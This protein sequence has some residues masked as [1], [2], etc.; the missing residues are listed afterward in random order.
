[1]E[2]NL[3]SPVTGFQ[4]MYPTMSFSSDTQII[5]NTMKERK[6]STNPLQGGSLS[7]FACLMNRSAL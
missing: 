7:G 3:S 5:W 4:Q 6:N 2:T 1:M